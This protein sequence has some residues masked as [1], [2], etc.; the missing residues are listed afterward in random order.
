MDF[1]FSSSAQADT[2][3]EFYRN[4]ITIHTRPCTITNR[5]VADMFAT[6]RLVCFRGIHLRKCT[7]LT[8]LISKIRKHIAICK[9]PSLKSL[10][11]CTHTHQSTINLCRKFVFFEFLRRWSY[12]K[13]AFVI[14]SDGICGRFQNVCRPGSEWTRRSLLKRFD[15][16]NT[17]IVFLYVN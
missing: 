14:N 13:F 4:N 1:L 2:S 10:V 7:P 3:I 16:E 15:N 11:E 17:Q 9:L 12:F 8:R 6:Q 5:A